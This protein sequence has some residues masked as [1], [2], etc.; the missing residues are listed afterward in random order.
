MGNVMTIKAGDRMPLGQFKVASA[1]GVGDLA[2]DELF[3]SKNVLLFGVPGAF[4]PTCDA[5]HLPG[6]VE[7]Y[8]ALRAKGIDTI[9]CMSVN[10]AFVMQ[11]WGKAQKADDKVLMLADGNGDYTRALGLELDARKFGMGPRAQRFAILVRDG[12]ATQ[13]HVEQGGELKVSSADYL[14]DRV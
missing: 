10:D 13:V 9:A 14:L 8:D 2:S 6:Y 12:V 5:R 11:A 7:K 1:D 3:R 4:T